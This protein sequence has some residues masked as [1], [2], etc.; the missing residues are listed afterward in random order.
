MANFNQRPRRRPSARERGSIYVLVLGV[1]MVI[2]AI[3]LSALM[4]SRVQH[5][6]SDSETEVTKAQFYAESVIDLAQWRIA[7]DPD[8][9]DD[10]AH[11]DWTDDEDTGKVIFAYKLVDQNDI[12]LADDPAD[13]LR[14]Y[15]KATVGDSTRIYSVLLQPDLP[16]NTLANADMESGTANWT[17][18]GLSGTCTLTS[19]FDT[20]HGGAAYLEVTGRSSS[21]AGPSQDITSVIAYGKTYYVEV[22]VRGTGGSNGKQ[23]VIEMDT[24]NGLQTV[25]FN[26]SWSGTNWH[27]MS[28]TLTPTWTG[29]LSA[30]HLKVCTTS[31]TLDFHID[32]ALLVE[33][34][35]PPSITL[36][37]IA[38]TWRQ[39]VASTAQ[40]PTADD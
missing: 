31:M 17:G 34:T 32:D 23:V 9:R 39:E 35:G 12:D 7:D 3:G 22:W 28:G 40:L 38:G 13:P 1:T 11:D 21:S 4:A 15:A 33:G 16:A 10:H 30:A 19:R 27:R 37:P 25:S 2:T 18:Q 24:S 5:R 8:W 36:H 14:V 6:V 26:D 20:P 29:T